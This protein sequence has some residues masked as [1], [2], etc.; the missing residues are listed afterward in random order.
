MPIPLASPAQPET[1]ATSSKLMAA[2]ERCAERVVGWMLDRQH[3]DD[4]RCSLGTLPRFIASE[5]SGETEG[6]R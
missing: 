4:L 6:T 5:T 3:D 2:L 1:R